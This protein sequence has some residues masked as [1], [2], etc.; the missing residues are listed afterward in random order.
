M[1]TNPIRAYFDGNPK[2]PGKQQPDKPYLLAGRASLGVMTVYKLL[3]GTSRYMLPTTMTKIV[4]ASGN[5]ISLGS[6]VAWNTRMAALM[7]KKV[8]SNPK[9]K[10]RY[11]KK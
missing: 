2:V 9:P 5:K 1:E 11:A 3:K 10:R 7:T 8:R 4:E 6:L